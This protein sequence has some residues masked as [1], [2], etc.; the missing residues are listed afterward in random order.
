MVILY[1]H[2][3][4]RKPDEP[5]SHRSWY[6]AQALCRAGHQVH[7]LTATQ[8]SKNFSEQI[9]DNFYVH[10]LTAPYRQTMGFWRRIY[11][12]WQFV[13]KAI[14]KSKEIPFEKIYA[15][16]TPLSIGL[17]ALW[18]KKKY[19]KNYLFEVRDLWPQVPVELGILKNP[20]LKKISYFLEKKIYQNAEKIVVLSPAMQNYV[21][22]IVP[23]KPAFCVPNM[24]DCSL[25]VPQE[26][27]NESV[28]RLM[29]AGSIGFANGLDRVIAWAEK[30][31]WAEFW[32]I[33]EGAKRQ[34]MENLVKKSK[35]NNVY[36]FNSRNKKSLQELFNQ[37]D[38]LIISFAD[39]KILETCSPNKFF[40][41]LAA[42]KICISNTT[43]WIKDLIEENQCGFYANTAEEFEK[44]LQNIVQNKN[45][46]RQMQAN[47]RKLAENS[48]DKNHLCK[49]IVALFGAT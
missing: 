41:A 25:F 39:Y 1:L 2:Q 44:K 19:K 7:I 33:G 9:T 42:G 30:C 4:F 46:Q 48:F 31:S 12:F 22:K 36:F 6:I 24:A 20:I 3:Y 10:Y 17:I 27:K 21:Q 43:G 37:A 14:R 13:Q 47:A 5:G 49:E 23:E 35:I 34:A 26:K 16:S 18:L 8:E 32:I 11:A 29:Y 40:D 15:T 38:A 45:L 28:F